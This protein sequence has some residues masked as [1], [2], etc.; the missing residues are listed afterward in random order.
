MKGLDTLERI[1]ERAI[2]KYGTDSQ[3]N[4]A[5]EELSELTKEICKHKRNSSNRERIIEE[6]AD[7]E[8]MLEQLKLIFE[9]TEQ[10]IGLQRYMK[11]KR[12]KIKL[13]N[14]Y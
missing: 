10:E 7:V 2:K 5:I 11:L 12:L 9:I 1:I 14:A 3:L 6:I 8:I 13:E 4:V